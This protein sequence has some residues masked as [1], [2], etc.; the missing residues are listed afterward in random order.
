[1]EDVRKWISDSGH[2]DGYSEGYGIGEFNNE[3]VYL[4]DDVPTIIKR[5]K[6]YIAKGY[7]LN[8]EEVSEPKIVN[9]YPLDEPCNTCKY[10]KV[11]S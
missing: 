6:G 7:I 10:C 4:I 11:Q 5:I 1:M 9:R 8:K 3:K 2:G